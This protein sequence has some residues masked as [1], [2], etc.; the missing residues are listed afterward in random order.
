MADEPKAPSSR[1]SVT[2]LGANCKV[3]TPE[4][5]GKYRI[6][7][8]NDNVGEIMIHN[9]EENPLKLQVMFHYQPTV[10]GLGSTIQWTL[11]WLRCVKPGDDEP[12]VENADILGCIGASTLG[13]PNAGGPY[14]DGLD[15]K[16]AKWSFG[17]ARADKVLLPPTSDAIVVRIGVTLPGG[18][19]IRIR[20]LELEYYY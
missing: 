4:N 9:E 12:P 18:G 7:S 5:D 13:S 6:S 19:D 10:F 16:T 3:V 17:L 2:I 14:W 11:G 20:S 1:A 8:P 15:L